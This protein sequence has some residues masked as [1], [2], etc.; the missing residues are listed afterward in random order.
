MQ[1]FVFCNLIKLDELDSTA[2]ILGMPKLSER[3][4]IIGWICKQIP[5]VE[6]EIKREPMKTKFT[7]EE[8]T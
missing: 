5:C 1:H 6:I 3:R 2:P 8:V 7:L 4:H